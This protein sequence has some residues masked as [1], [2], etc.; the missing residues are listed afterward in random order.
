MYAAPMIVTS[1]QARTS[2]RLSE[3]AVA[4]KI[5]MIRT[6]IAQNSVVSGAHFVSSCAPATRSPACSARVPGSPDRAI[7][8][9]L[10][11]RTSSSDAA[12]DRR[13]QTR[14]KGATLGLR[15]A[16][17]GSTALWRCR[18]SLPGHAYLVKRRVHGAVEVAL[19]LVRRVLLVGP[20][21]L[22]RPRRFL[23]ADPFRHAL[24]LLVRGDFEML[25]RI[26]EARELPGR[27]RVRL[28]E[29]PPVQRSRAHGRVLQGRRVASA[30]F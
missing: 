7:R 15:P 4:I 5:A 12:P 22:G 25:E 20:N 1:V 13:K 28:E 14:E 30:H 10:L 24:Q 9:P 23:V 17:G 16:A 6:A 27:V 8:F 18:C 26:G 11:V 19:Q 3:I 2:S 29:H 21:P